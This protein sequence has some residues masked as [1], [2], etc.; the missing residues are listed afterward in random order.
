MT[1]ISIAGMGLTGVLRITWVHDNLAHV[2]DHS[3]TD[4]TSG[5]WTGLACPGHGLAVGT[6]VDD[7]TLQRLA[8]GSEIADL[9]WEAPDELTADHAE[10]FQAAMRAHHGGDSERAEPALGEP[11]GHLVAGLVSELRG[12]RV[13]AGH[14]PDPVRAG[15]APALGGRLLRAP[16]QPSRPSP[17]S[18][19]QHRPHQL[20]T[21]GLRRVMWVRSGVGGRDG[22]RRSRQS[23]LPRLSL[24][25]PASQ[26]SKRVVPCRTGGLRLSRAVT[27]V[28]VEHHRGAV[29]R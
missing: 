17:S 20:S 6:D 9:T 11:P 5:T 29:P 10:V 15:Q 19:P 12:A 8:A 4:E 16:H 23:Q 7:A 22:E 1:A 3:H 26:S 13:H 2:L 24:H 28:Q 25:G 18:C 27:G 14:G 21:G